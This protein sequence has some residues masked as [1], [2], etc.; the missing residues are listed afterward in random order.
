V[1]DER[2]ALRCMIRR[3]VRREAARFSEPV[4]S[5]A[6]WKSI[7][8]GHRSCGATKGPEKSTERA[9]ASP[10]HKVSA[11]IDRPRF[12]RWRTGS[13]SRR[14]VLEIP[15]CSPTDTISV[16]LS[17]IYIVPLTDCGFVQGERLGPVLYRVVAQLGIF[18]D[19]DEPAT[20]ASRV[21]LARAAW[22][23][24]IVRLG[25]WLRIKDIHSS[26]ATWEAYVLMES[27]R[28]KTKRNRA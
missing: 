9:F 21:E 24:R 5:G 8:I 18:L 20:S 6:S 4:P 13:I 17:F 19:C 3:H 22:C 14:R 10:F 26:T 25:R 15:T 1:I 7:G 28:M 27:D 2:S 12:R 11:E 16:V 23:G